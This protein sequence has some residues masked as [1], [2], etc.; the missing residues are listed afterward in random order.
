MAVGTTRV[1]Q[2][3]LVALLVP[4]LFTAKQTAHF[5]TNF[6]T[7]CWLDVATYATCIT[8]SGLLF[9]IGCSMVWIL[10]ATVQA[11][12]QVLGT[13]VALRA[14]RLLGNL[15]FF[16]FIDIACM[17]SSGLVIESARRHG[18]KSALSCILELFATPAV[19]KR[20]I[21]PIN[22]LY[23]PKTFR[24]SN[25]NMSLLGN[26]SV[27][28]ADLGVPMSLAFCGTMEIAF[29]CYNMLN[30]YRALQQHNYLLHGVCAFRLI[31]ICGVAP[32]FF[33]MV[34]HSG[35]S[36]F[37][38]SDTCV[39]INGTTLILGGFWILGV[40]V[41]A[42]FLTRTR[43]ATKESQI[44]PS[45][46]IFG[47]VLQFLTTVY[48]SVD[49]H[50][51]MWISDQCTDVFS[52]WPFGFTP[53]FVTFWILFGCGESKQQTRISDIVSELGGN[54]IRGESKQTKIMLSKFPGPRQYA[55]LVRLGEATCIM[56][57]SVYIA[58]CLADIV[59][60]EKATLLQPAFF[61][62]GFCTSQAAVKMGISTHIIAALLDLTCGIYLFSAITTLSR[63]HDYTSVFI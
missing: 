29:F 59:Y 50:K 42:V 12:T 48:F 55:R 19:S 37:G 33:Y 52:I 41:A 47:R 24:T 11:L 30:V 32:L 46:Y 54:F 40:E 7:S 27:S 44:I 4:W 36:V 28:F 1:A 10:L 62:E 43:E 63:S 38:S 35:E 51:M 49:V 57:T 21:F 3:T 26:K 14:H 9:H 56:L 45:R 58:L 2:A 18:N 34:N 5:V 25:N 31:A 13:P 6:P 17:L 61:R 20:G 60:F 23:N 22:A 8:D 16:A 39:L 15:A 53:M